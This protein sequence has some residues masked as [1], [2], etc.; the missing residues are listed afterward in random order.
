MICSFILLCVLR[1][2]VACVL[3]QGGVENPFNPSAGEAARG[4]TTQKKKANVREGL[5]GTKT[6]DD[7]DA[8]ED[9]DR[10]GATFVVNLGG[11]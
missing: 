11:G 9:N 2:H 1:V 7:D 5:F 4:F 3:V 6:G 10:G 8:S